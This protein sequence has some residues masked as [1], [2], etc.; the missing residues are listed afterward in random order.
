MPHHYGRFL[1]FSSRYIFHTT[2]LFTSWI[3]GLS[4]SPMD[5]NFPR[6]CYTTLIHGGK[7]NIDTEIAAL[8]NFKH[9][10]EDR[11]LP[12]NY[13]IIILYMCIIITITYFNILVVT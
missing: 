1:A 11:D 3:A 13:N 9:N 10:I 8:L 12:R 2:K 5:P 6:G 7:P 4:A